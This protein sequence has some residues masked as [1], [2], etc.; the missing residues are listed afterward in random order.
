MASLAALVASAFAAA[1]LASP[2]VAADGSGEAVIRPA[3]HAQGRTL[4]GQG[5]K[6]LAGPGASSANGMLSL[7]IGSLETGAVASASASSA[8]SFQ[9]GRRHV[10]L[11][12]IRFDLARNELVGSLG[13]QQ[14][15]VFKLGG[16]A[17][18]DAESVALPGGK[19]SLT[20]AAAKA[21]RQ[22]LGLERALVLRGVG[23]IWVSARVTPPTPTPAIPTGP[24]KVVAGEV[25]WGV[26]AS[27]RSYILGN[28]GPGSVGT[29]GVEGGATAN[30]TLSA[31]GAFF[32]LPVSGGSF[33]SSG[34]KLGLTTVGTLVFAKPGHCIDEVEFSGIE[35]ALDGAS[36]LLTLDARNAIRTPAGMTCAANPPVA[37]DDVPFATLDLSAVTP[38]TSGDTMTWTGVPATLTAAGSSA[39]GM[40]P[41]YVA[42]KQLDPV[43][44]TVELG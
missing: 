11:T 19:L 36:S 21:L 32:G 7:P 18:S 9:R 25:D 26:L 35:V 38:S 42:G 13:G 27:F 17:S 15:A 5:V 1:A 12:G 3:D 40:G 37:S 23:M 41:P 31:A 44:I 28:F 24:R 10:A 33:E 39:W 29:I 20:A 6:I 22:K 14:L 4:S 8:L 16:G 2:A 34:G 30:G 43:T